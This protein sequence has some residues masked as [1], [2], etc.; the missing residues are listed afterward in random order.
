MAAG[1]Q[2]LTVSFICTWLILMQYSFS[3]HSLLNVNVSVTAMSLPLGDLSIGRNLPQASDCRQRCS[4]K[5]SAMLRSCNDRGNGLTDI[6]QMLDLLVGERV[7][8]LEQQQYERLEQRHVQLLL[9]VAESRLH[10]DLAE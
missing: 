9:N 1:T 2:P 4:S 8:L 5:S 6:R 3:L 7:V 10:H